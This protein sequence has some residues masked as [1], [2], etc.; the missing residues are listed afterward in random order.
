M[1]EQVRIGIVGAGGIARNHANGLLAVPHAR[2]TAVVDVRPERAAQMAQTV[3]AQVYP[4]L[5]ACLPDVDLVYVLTPPSLH[6]QLAV[7]ALEAGKPVVVEKPLAST[8]EDGE[9]MVA[10]AQRTGVA[11][12][13]AFNMR[14]RPGFLRLKD[15]LGGGKLGK[16]IS[17]WSHRL[18][19]GV[20]SGENWRTTPG[21]LCGMSVESLSHDIDLIR[22][23]LCDIVQV[24]A[25]IRES[26]ANLPGFDDNA[27]VV[28][29]LANGAYATIHASWSSHIPY[30]SRGLVGEQGTAMVTGRGLWELTTF[31]LKTA[32][33]P[34][35]QIEVLNDSLDVASYREEGR[36]FVDCVATGRTS[37]I[38]GEDG[39]AALRVSHAILASQAQ[40]QTIA[41]RE[42]A[43][44]ARP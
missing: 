7:T 4:T 14:F 6:R 3:G 42:V 30:N 10:A 39:L 11:L 44:G 41:L 9:A 36:Y 16:P 33:M 27:A 2:I 21:L 24:A 31:H 40:G 38:T 29:D 19:M 43:I 17:F 22:W 12:M 1:A 20:G 26:R 15:A 37:S 34:Y 23:L 35:E 8:L 13:T 28:F 25:Q 32:E 5:E 18:G